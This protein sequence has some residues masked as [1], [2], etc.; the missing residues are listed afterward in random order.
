MKAEGLYWLE[1]L[2]LVVIL[3][4]FVMYF[5]TVHVRKIFQRSLFLRQR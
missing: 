2:I 1:N 3:V 4:Y 5:F